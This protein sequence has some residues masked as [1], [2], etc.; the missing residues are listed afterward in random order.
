M[1]VVE[2]EAKS[3][4]V[5]SKLPDADYVL[6]PYTGCA[7][8]CSYCYASFMSRYV[9]EEISAWGEYV[10][11][12]TNAVEIAR[13][14]VKAIKGAKRNSTLLLSSVT[15]PYQGVES[16][17]RLTRGILEVLVEAQW[18]G[19]V[20]ILTK[21]PLV[22][23]DIDVLRKLPRPEVG[24]TVTSTED[25]I[26]KWLEVRAPKA[27]S[28]LRALRELADAGLPVYAFVG[29]LL[30]HFHSKPDMLEKLFAGLA[31]AGVQEIYV[32]HINL[33][34]Y[35]RSRLEPRLESEPQHVRDA[36]VAAR[37][38]DY[39][40]ELGK[41]VDELKAKYGMRLR[42][43]EVLYHQAGVAAAAVQAA[44]PG[45]RSDG[46]LDSTNPPD[47]PV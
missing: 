38:D 1:R 15:D 35:I 9:G 32:E 40:S 31:E 25:N 29:P 13:K 36:Y 34:A 16:K 12:K 37:R 30:P 19:R 5:P 45:T 17:Y 21:S 42:L 4:L 47:Q 8:G 18:P 43:D 33:K 39:R 22:T 41:V 3:I 23:R 44:A 46:E 10:Y 26:S 11:V 6:N 7:F 2:V 14:D 27:S 24:L 28:R 20:G